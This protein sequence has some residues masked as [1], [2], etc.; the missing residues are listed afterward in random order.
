M[1]GSRG[2][3]HQLALHDL[4]DER[5]ERGFLVG[6]VVQLRDGPQG[7]LDDRRPADHVGESEDARLDLGREAKQAHDLAHPGAGNPLPAGDIGLVG[8]LAR[9]EEGLPLEN[10]AE[11][12]DHPA[13][14]GTDVPVLEGSLG[15]EGDLDR[16][17]TVGARG[18]I[19]DVSGHV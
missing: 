18:G 10:L 14:Q 11:E 4:L 3:D 13:R 19:A 15:P 17:F 5:F 1:S 12:F 8:G 16:L 9:L 2:P 7:A 6:D